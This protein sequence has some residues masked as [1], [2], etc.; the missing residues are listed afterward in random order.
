VPRLIVWPEG[1]V[2]D[3]LESGYPDYAYLGRP[4]A[5]LRGR[6]ADGLGPRDL[7]MTNAPRLNFDADGNIVG[8]ANSV[9]AIDAD[10]RIAGI[11]DKA[12]LVPYGEYLPMP[13]LLKPLGLARLV[14]GD[15]DFTPGPGPRNLPIPGF[16]PVGVQLC[17]EIIFSGQVVDEAH[18]PRLLFNPS[19]DAWFGRW[20]PPQHLAQARMRAIEEGLPIIR[21]TPTGISA[22]IAADGRLIAAVPHETAGSAEAPL[23]AALPPTLFSRVGNMLALV[24]A[25]A[26]AAIG[27]AIRRRGR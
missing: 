10:A 21:A 22:I 20:G 1:L 23:P 13:W 5:W 17:Y 26:L 27:V 7:L 18:R 19:N 25:A 24:V 14:P 11:Y 9:L 6:I 2:Q 12:H 8:A 3:M 15:M 16:G 4:P